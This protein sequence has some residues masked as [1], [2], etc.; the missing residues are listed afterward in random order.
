MESG[1][2]LGQLIGAAAGAGLAVPHTPYWLG[3]TVGGLL[4]VRTKLDDERSACVCVCL[5]LV[6][7]ERGMPGE[8][9]PGVHGHA[10][11]CV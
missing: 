5:V 9:A 3:L 1:V 10:C 2:T 11:V 8:C 4:S 6:R 7:G